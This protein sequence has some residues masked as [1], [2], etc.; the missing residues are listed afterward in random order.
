[1][2]TVALPGHSG[3]PHDIN[4]R[5]KLEACHRPDLDVFLNEFWPA[6]RRPFFQP[7]PGCSD[8][9]FVGSAA[10]V[11][12]L[13]AIMLNRAAAELSAARAGVTATGHF[14]TPP[15]VLNET[16][17]AV[18]ASFAWGPDLLSHDLHAGYQIRISPPC[19]A[20]IGSWISKS[21]DVGGPEVETGGLLFGERD[22]AAGVIWVSEVSGP[23]PD[24]SSAPEEFICGVEG[25][26][27]MNA[28]KRTRSRES[29]HYIGMWHTHPSSMPVPSLTDWNGMNRLVTAAG[30]AARSLMLIVGCPQDTPMLGTYVFKKS[31]FRQEPGSVVFRPCVIKTTTWD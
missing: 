10:D 14:V 4:R 17:H 29:V 22:E 8:A 31:D 28:E 20:E 18:S 23:P 11:A 6:E 7:E 13:A 15:H 1:M 24:S 27:E 19:W 12:G 30:G 25:T 3:G 21:R 26:A 9:T 16:G 5:L 2:V